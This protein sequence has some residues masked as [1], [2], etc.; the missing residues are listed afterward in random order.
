MN[1]P[2]GGELFGECSFVRHMSHERY[3]RVSN[4]VMQPHYFRFHLSIVCKIFA[5]EVRQ[6][7][8]E[9]TP[10]RWIKIAERIFVFRKQ[11]NHL[12]QL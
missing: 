11:C 7:S 1:K 2:I 5:F 12:I 4:G 10:M 6:K 3:Q 9:T 8:A